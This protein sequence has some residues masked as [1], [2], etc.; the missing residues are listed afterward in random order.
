VLTTANPD[1]LCAVGDVL[2]IIGR[3]LDEP[4]KHVPGYEGN[5]P[6]VLLLGHAVRAP[7]IE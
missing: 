3:I 7:K 6:R 2:V 4:Q 5:Q 1:D